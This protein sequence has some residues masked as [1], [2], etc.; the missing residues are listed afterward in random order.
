MIMADLKLDFCTHDA[1]RHAVMRWHY[2]RAMPSAKLVRIGVW[3]AKRFVGAILYGCGANRH[4]SRPFGLEP[5]QACEL[6]RVAL[7][8]GREHPTSRCVAISLKLLK[9]QSPG[10]RLVVSYADTKEGHLGII[11]Q[12]TNWLFL[13]GS[14]QP[15]LKVKGEIVHPRSLYDRYGP[16]GQSVDWLRTHVD[17]RAERVEMK[18]KLKYVY[19]FD[20]ELRR[21]L[22][23]FAKPYPKRAESIASDAPG[24][25]PGEGG[26]TPTS[27]LQS[28]VGSSDGAAPGDQPGEGGSI[29]TPTLQD[30]HAA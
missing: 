11:Y 20:P 19:V 21:Q 8:P 29:P 16:G 18:P 12:A 27:A 6:V 15:Y 9:K 5:T 26:A 13:G 1:A 22:E 4:L 30:A 24:F 3:E 2:S 28:R 17:P 7:A 23:A 25:Q 10:L 14:T